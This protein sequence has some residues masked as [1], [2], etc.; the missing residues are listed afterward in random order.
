MRRPL[1]LFAALPLLALAAAAPL[2]AD[3]NSSSASVGG[4]WLNLPQSPRSAAMGGAAGASAQGSAAL[5]VNPA[6][7][8]SQQGFEASFSSLQW[9]EDVRLQRL[10]LAQQA[11]TGAAFGLS[12]DYLDL[13]SV[14]RFGLVN[15]APVSLGDFHPNAIDAGLD[16]AQAVGERW[17]LGL[18]LNVITQ[19]LGSGRSL[20]FAGDLGATWKPLPALNLGLSLLNVGT[21]L[22][23]SRLPLRVRAGVAYG[24]ALGADTLQLSA[25]SLLSPESD[26]A[27]TGLVGVEYGVQ[28]T[29][30]LRGGYRLGSSAAMP[31]GPAAGIGLRV[32]YL[33]VD[34]SYSVIGPIASNQIALTLMTSPPHRTA[35]P[36][37]V[38][39]VPAP[40]PTAP[41]E[42]PAPLVDDL[43]RLVKAVDAGDTSNARSSLDHLLQAPP[44][45]RHADSTTL[46]DSVLAPTLFDGE[47]EQAEK[48]LRAMV[49]MDHANAY[50]YMALG[51]VCWQRGKADEAILNLRKAY[52]LDPSL[53]FIPA[54]IKSMQE[55][56]PATP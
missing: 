34:Y 6:E 21:P 7:L 17:S 12:L 37:A 46:K 42:A 2:W 53:E 40:A 45:T 38:A 14:E 27:A 55:P 51:S 43:K 36:V 16:F 44:A 4:R 50:N 32:S 13:G 31:A 3:G 24:F 33:R 10:G 5:G 20:A 48:Y 15:G 54:Q 49:E 9:A 22:D 8:A 56:P 18:G 47:L 23:G 29:V 30:F 19:E 26:E 1:Q 25:D 39:P 35:A 52:A 28:E 11:W 41:V